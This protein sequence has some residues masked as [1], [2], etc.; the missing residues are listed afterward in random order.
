MKLFAIFTAAMLPL[1]SSAAEKTSSKAELVAPI[2]LF[3][4]QT[5]QPPPPPPPPPPK[6]TAPPLPFQYG[7]SLHDGDQRT[8]F[9]IHQKRQLIVRTGDVIDSTYRVEEISPQ[10]I[11]LMYLPLQQKQTLLTGQH[12]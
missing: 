6:P 10:R 7:G 5:W 1:L 12:P 4:V 2:N 11:E 9:L 8:I 3:P